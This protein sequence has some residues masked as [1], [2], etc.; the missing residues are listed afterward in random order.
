MRKLPSSIDNPVDN[1]LVDIADH[2]DPY[3]KALNMTPNMITTL[4]L[5][6]ALVSIYKFWVGEYKSSAIFFFLSYF[7]DC[8]DGNFARKY[9]MVTDFGDYYDHTVDISKSIIIYSLLFYYLYINDHTFIIILLVLLLVLQLVHFGCQEKYVEKTNKAISSYTLAPLKPLCY[10]PSN[11]IE[12]TMK[13]VRFVG[14]GT[15]AL[16]TA[17][18][19][20]NLDKL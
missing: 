14:S 8:V 2:I 20:Y 6:S 1:L 4:G 7:F 17:I 10:A 5:L 15:C 13:F 18:I 16:V 12:N 19:I 9:N 3:M 11:D